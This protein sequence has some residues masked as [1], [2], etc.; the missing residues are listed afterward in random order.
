MLTRNLKHVLYTSLIRNE[1][2]LEMSEN[3][4]TL[5]KFLSHLSRQLI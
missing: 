1:A 2:T 3:F 5:S 4:I